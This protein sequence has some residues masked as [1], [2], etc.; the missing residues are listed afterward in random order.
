MAYTEMDRDR[1]KRAIASGV[2]TVDYPERGRVTYRSLAELRSAL[3]AVEAEIG[4]SGG[5]IPTRRVV[6]TSSSGF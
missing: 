2:L 1:L 4:Q 6:V 5:L 3:A